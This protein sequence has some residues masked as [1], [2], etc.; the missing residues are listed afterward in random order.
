[1]KLISLHLY[2]KEV[3]NDAQMTAFSLQQSCVVQLVFFFL[4]VLGCQLYTCI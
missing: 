3:H 1:M 4:Y 2:K